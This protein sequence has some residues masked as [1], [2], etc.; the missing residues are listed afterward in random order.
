MW[1][2]VRAL[3]AAAGLG[4]GLAASVRSVAAC[5]A[6]PG[7][8]SAGAPGAGRL[9]GAHRLPPPTPKSPRL[10][11]VTVPPFLSAV[12]L[13][14]DFVSACICC[15]VSR[16]PGVQDFLNW[17]GR[18]WCRIFLRI[19]MGNW[20]V[21]RVGE[22]RGCRIGPRVR[23]LVGRLCDDLRS[24]ACSVGGLGWYR[25]AGLASSLNGSNITNWDHFGLHDPVTLF[26]PGAIR[27]LG[28]GRCPA[29]HLQ[30]SPRIV[31]AARLRSCF[32]RTRGD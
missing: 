6:G 7:P 29:P 18:V 19:R 24:L 17:L 23:G 1:C 13:V 12:V 10:L 31:D 22:H 9:A 3:G 11:T 14:F 28:I 2:T 4:P 5:A 26:C 20:G 16:F 15:G 25:L 21:F 8:W 32:S 27:L 30:I